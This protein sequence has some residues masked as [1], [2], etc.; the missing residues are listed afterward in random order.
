MPISLNTWTPTAVDLARFWTR[1]DKRGPDDCWHWTG[2]NSGGYG[3]YAIFG[4][5]VRAH[6]VSWFLEHGHL[7]DDLDI[8]HQ[9]H[10]LDKACPGGPTCP[11]RACVNPAH[12]RSATRA[13]NLRAGR[14]NPSRTHCP[15]GHEYTPENTYV[16][17]RNQRSCKKC[18]N[19]KSNAIHK[20]QYAEAR[21]EK[22]RLGIPI[23]QPRLLT[24]FGETKSATEWSKDPRFKTNYYSMLFRIDRYGWD[25]ERAIT[26]PTRKKRP[27]HAGMPPAT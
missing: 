24:A 23:Q 15:Q 8:D 9:C 6:R 12:L 3:V 26:T 10:N 22:I 25:V 4:A 2:S 16:S 18:S 14:G 13:V 19:A 20:R 1:V 5:A 11:H 21:A 27:N 7:P 17:P